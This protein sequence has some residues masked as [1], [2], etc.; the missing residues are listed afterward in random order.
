[1]VDRMIERG[2]EVT[3]E[4]PVVIKRAEV[5]KQLMPEALQAVKLRLANKS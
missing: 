2:M 1:M 5:L 3:P 4:T